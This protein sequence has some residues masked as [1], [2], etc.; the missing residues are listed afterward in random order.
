MNQDTQHPTVAS[1][2]VNDFSPPSEPQK[3]GPKGGPRLSKSQRLEQLLQQNLEQAKALKLEL[4]KSKREE[5]EELHAANLKV[6]KDAGLLD[7]DIHQ[8][9][10][11]IEKVKAVFE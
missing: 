3:R 7:L 6:I 11:H 1:G 5:T 4:E 8:W 9:R 2:D 10:K